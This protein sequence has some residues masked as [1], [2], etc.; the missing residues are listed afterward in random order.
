MT[1]KFTIIITNEDIQQRLDKFLANKFSTIEPKLSRNRIQTLI[2][3]GQITCDN[4][5][6]TNCDYKIKE[7]QQFIVNIPVPKKSEIIA[8]DIPFK[9]IFEDKN[10]LVIDKPAGLTTHPGNGNQQH[11]LVNSLLF[12]C[13]ETLS[14]IN[15]IMRPG[16]VHRLDKD[17]SGLMVVAKNDL[18][19]QNLAQQIFQRTLK[20]NYLAICYGTPKPLKDTINKNIVRSKINRLKMITSKTSGRISIT[21]YQVEKIYYNGD[22]SLIKCQLDTGRTHQIRVHLSSI[23]HSI[24]GDQTYG[25]RKKPLKNTNETIKTLINNLKRQALHSYKITFIHPIS[26]EEMTFES[27]L[28][29]EINELI[30]NN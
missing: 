30:N 18:A 20:R 7:N 11:T 5:E 27:K 9:I 17:T 22:F 14:G 19:H 1:K 2:E 23:G 4:Q 3:S 25:N 28:P 12:H 10:M 26:Q 13:G 29:P 24:I 21:N 15:G 6:I 8:K 16:I